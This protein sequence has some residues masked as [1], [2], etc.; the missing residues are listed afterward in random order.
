MAGL[1][2]YWSRTRGARPSLG[3][4]EAAFSRCGWMGW[5]AQDKCNK[6]VRIKP[7]QTKSNQTGGSP[8]AHL[9]LPDGRC[10]V[11]LRWS[12]NGRHFA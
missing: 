1:A 6:R 8:K 3:G 12:P 5:D 2:T 4:I 10:A 9:G 11:R 7:N